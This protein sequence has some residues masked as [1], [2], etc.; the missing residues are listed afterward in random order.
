MQ[1]VLLTGSNDQRTIAWA[2]G[3]GERAAATDLP[4]TRRSTFGSPADFAAGATSQ[5]R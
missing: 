1:I 4:Q 2:R 3:R 5:V